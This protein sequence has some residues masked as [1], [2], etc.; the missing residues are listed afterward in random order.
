MYVMKKDF[1]HDEEEIIT[2]R[3]ASRLER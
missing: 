3:K 1:N 2:M